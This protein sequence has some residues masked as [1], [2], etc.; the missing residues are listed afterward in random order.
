[1]TVI[2]V[3]IYVLHQYNT[4]YF[5]STFITDTHHVRHCISGTLLGKVPTN[6]NLEP[7]HFLT[8]LNQTTVNDEESF[9]RI[10][11]E[12][13]WDKNS[14]SASGP[15]STLKYTHETMGMLHMMVNQIKAAL[16]VDRISMLDVPCGD[17]NWMKRF[18]SARNDID[19]TGIDI[20][21]DIIEKHKKEFKGTPYK[22]INANIVKVGLAT[23]LLSVMYHLA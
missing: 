13:I 17:M 19:Y 21:P 6:L 10:Y 8:P 1:M 9:T 20:V 22:F 4:S 15:G 23:F 18:L 12:K 11:K 7:I 14:E 5:K 2:H 3:Y 16:N